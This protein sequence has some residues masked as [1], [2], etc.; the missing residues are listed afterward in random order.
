MKH[1]VLMGRPHQEDPAS[2]IVAV[3]TTF[4]RIKDK[5]PASQAKAFI[6]DP[7]SN[8]LYLPSL[9]AEFQYAYRQ[10]KRGETIRY[11]GE[12]ATDPPESAD[13]KLCSP[14]R[15]SRMAARILGRE[16]N[17]RVEGNTPSYRTAANPY[18]KP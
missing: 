14:S 4:N 7:I 6:E 13:L 9:D 3:L 17:Y 15:A 10:E 12:L 16:C 5:V 2:D 11:S 18:K 1:G 8:P